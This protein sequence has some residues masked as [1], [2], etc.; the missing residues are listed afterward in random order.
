M[1]GLRFYFILI[2]L[3]VSIFFV[4]SPLA[5]RKSGVVVTS[6]RNDGCGDL[7]EGDVITQIGG[8]VVKSAEEFN[9]FVSGVERDRYYPMVVNN[10]PGGCTAL[11]DG[12]IVVGVTDMVSSGLRFERSIGGGVEMTVVP[13]TMLSESELQET[14]E[15]IQSRMAAL[16]IIDGTVE[17]ENEKFIISSS[18]NKNLGLLIKKGRIEGVIRQTLEVRNGN[19]EVKIGSSRYSIGFLNGIIIVN[20]SE[21]EVGGEFYLENVKFVF[22]NGTNTSLVL[23]SLIFDNDNIIGEIEGAD[24]VSFEPS[25]N[26]YRSTS[27]VEIDR[28]SGEKFGKISNGLSTVLLG[29]QTFLNGVW[30]YYVDGKK[31]NGIG[32][33]ILVEQAGQNISTAFIVGFGNS[34]ND[35][36]TKK[37]SVGFAIAGELPSKFEIETT[38]RTQPTN[39]WLIWM[40]PFAVAFLSLTAI[41]VSRKKVKVSVVMIVMTILEV[42]YVFGIF[43]I[44]QNFTSWV[45]DTYALIGVCMFLAIGMFD[46]ITLSKS[47]RKGKT[48]KKLIIVASVVGFITLFTPLRGLGIALI[49]GIILNRILTNPFYKSLRMD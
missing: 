41:L 12:D 26:L 19:S 34:M 6:V 4:L 44:I 1:K 31:I 22:V 9:N 43:A 36:V 35:V 7:S 14:K 37:T 3:A 23:N 47:G 42:V 32:I 25:V 16:G 49:L 8:K 17:V 33:P 30:E 27:P 45:I 46:M 28:E 39:W 21:I 29:P 13:D 15:I 18:P 20:G 5:F 10:G 24:S 48:M 40:V 11:S 2:L 38:V